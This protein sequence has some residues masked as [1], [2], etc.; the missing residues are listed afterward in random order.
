MTTIQLDI[1]SQLDGFVLRG[2]FETTAAQLI[3][4]WCIRKP[5]RRVT[6]A[7]LQD[8][9]AEQLALMS[10]GL[11]AS[12][13]A[14]VVRLTA[15]GRIELAG[16]LLQLAPQRPGTEDPTI[17]DT[18]LEMRVLKFLM[19]GPIGLQELRKRAADVP[20]AMQLALAQGGCVLGKRRAIWSRAITSVPAVIL[21]VRTARLMA[22]YGGANGLPAL[23]IVGLVLIVFAVRI[24]PITPAGERAL[25]QLRR[26]HANLQHKGT[27][28]RS[29][30]EL[31]LGFALF[32]TSALRSH[33]DALAGCISQAGSRIKP[34]LRPQETHYAPAPGPW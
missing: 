11:A 13:D 24:S 7:E 18:Q 22:H 17:E 30:H 8:L 27:T 29:P 32:G 31:K 15:L 12:V 25:A 3:L 33:L 19:S 5:W 9:T 10:G 28:T 4:A 6:R 26:D 16:S 21:I 2:F 20:L 34:P 1:S 14:A 23:L